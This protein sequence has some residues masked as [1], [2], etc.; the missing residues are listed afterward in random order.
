M[1]LTYTVAIC[2]YRRPQMLERT[3]KRWHEHFGNDS[4]VEILIINNGLD[5]ETERLAS[6]SFGCNPIIH[7]YEPQAGVSHA[8][9][10]AINAAKSDV[11]AFLDDD[12]L[13]DATWMPSLRERF[14]AD[15]DRTMGLLGGPINLHWDSPP[16]SWYHP[17]FIGCYSGMHWGEGDFQ[18]TSSNQWLGEGNCAYWLS[19][20]KEFGGFTVRLGRKKN[21]LLSNEG[22]ELRQR[23][24]AKGYEI[25]YTSKM[26]VS[27]IVFEERT[28]SSNWMLKRNFWSGVSYEIQE[29]H[30]NRQTK[31]MRRFVQLL[32]QIIRQDLRYFRFREINDFEQLERAM[33]AYQRLG[34][35]Y[36]MIRY[37]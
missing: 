19:R 16:P 18:L 6:Q 13:V 4:D 17:R 21:Q 1:P 33:Q 24:E 14:E 25:W 20:I 31:S 2:T 35:L 15:T 23:I 11:L 5:L 9:N 10:A 8:R 22:N 28:R 36:A 29:L 37:R 30:L 32:K 7:V 3:L 12:C 34:M 27:H 26:L